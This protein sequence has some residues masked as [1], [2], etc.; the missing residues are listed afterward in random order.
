[1]FASANVTGATAEVERQLARCL[2]RQM[3]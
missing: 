3:A 2:L 1:V